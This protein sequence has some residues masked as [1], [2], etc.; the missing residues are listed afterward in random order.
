MMFQKAMHILQRGARGPFRGLKGRAALGCGVARQSFPQY[1]H[2]RHISGQEGRT[3]LSQGT[4]YQVEAAKRFARAGNAGDENNIAPTFHTRLRNY[5]RNGVGGA[6]QVMRIGACG[7]DIGHGIAP[8]QKPRRFQH[9]WYGAIGGTRPGIRF[10]G[11]RWRRDGCL[12]ARHNI[13]QHSAIGDHHRRHTMP[14]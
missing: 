2:Q 12:R 13:P 3:G 4:K 5:A 1:R 10:N 6:G 8:I 9:A 11:R 14:E 7:A